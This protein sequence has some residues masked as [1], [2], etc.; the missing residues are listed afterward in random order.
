MTPC[1]AIPNSTQRWPRELAANS[2]TATGPSA[3]QLARPRTQRRSGQSV[4][5]RLRRS[6]LPHRT[7]ARY[8]WSEQ[9]HPAIRHWQRRQQGAPIRCSASMLDPVGAHR[10][11][12]QNDSLVGLGW[13]ADRRC[14]R[15]RTL[16][17]LASQRGGVLRLAG[18]PGVPS[19]RRRSSIM[20]W[21]VLSFERCER[22]ERYRSFGGAGSR[23][24]G[25]RVRARRAWRAGWTARSRR[26]WRGSG[27]C[28][29]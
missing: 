23:W 6:T 26:R 3:D 16:R 2:H 19:G 25:S 8:V 15:Q 22:C 7:T 5:P 1:R 29:W 18:E 9:S 11:R 28:S 24:V 10:T 21:G 20:S 17:C 12:R 13:R 14:Q 4:A 27:A